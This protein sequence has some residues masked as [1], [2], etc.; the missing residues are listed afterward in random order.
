MSLRPAIVIVPGHA[1]VAW[2]T[3]EGSDEWRYLETTMIATHTFEEAAAS[4]EQTAQRYQALASS[5]GQAH[6]FQRHALRELRAVRGITPL[7]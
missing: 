7:E 4:G 3:W 5:T 6:Y 1:F 2:E